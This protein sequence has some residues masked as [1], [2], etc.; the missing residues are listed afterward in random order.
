MVSSA[1]G[2]FSMKLLASIVEIIA[3]F[4]VSSNAKLSRLSIEIVL[5]FHQRLLS[6]SCCISYMH[7]ISFKAGF[8]RR[9]IK[10]QI[11]TE[12]LWKWFW[13]QVIWWQLSR[14]GH[15]RP[16][17][18]NAY[19]KSQMQSLHIKPSSSGVR[20]WEYFQSGRTMLW[21]LSWICLD[22]HPYENSHITITLN[23]TR[24]FSQ[25]SQPLVV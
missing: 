3:P 6:N 22:M 5:S 23:H 25:P 15:Q 10:M 13:W 9:K 14:I 16:P 12:V 1:E 17:Q 11:P 20:Q 2:S 24:Y 8:W 18:P 19:L 21:Q 7:F 4:E